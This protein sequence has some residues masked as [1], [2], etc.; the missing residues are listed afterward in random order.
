MP[1]TDPTKKKKKI[2]LLKLKM[3]ICKIKKYQNKKT[4]LYIKLLISINHLI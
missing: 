1:I 3:N 4:K 2:Y